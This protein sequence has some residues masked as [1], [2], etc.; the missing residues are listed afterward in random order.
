[1]IAFMLKKIEIK[2]LKSFILQKLKK[3]IKNNVI[4]IFVFDNQT[5]S[6]M[7]KQV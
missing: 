3:I 2:L 1:M 7:E 5:I 4:N 6:I